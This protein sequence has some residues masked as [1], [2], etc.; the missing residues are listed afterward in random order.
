MIGGGATPEQSIPTWLISLKCA[1]LAETERALRAHDPAI[2]ARIEDGR[3]VFDLRT[4]FRSEEDELA[5][6]LSAIQSRERSE[7]PSPN[8]R[9]PTP[10][11]RS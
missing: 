1:N 11:A 5:A 7:P 3:L 8:P 4:V 9:L 2:L 10:H 6:A